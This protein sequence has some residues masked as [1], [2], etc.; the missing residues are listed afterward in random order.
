MFPALHLFVPLGMCDYLNVYHNEYAY[1][2][3]WRSSTLQFLSRNGHLM[4]D[5]PSYIA[6]GHDHETQDI[7]LAFSQ[8][9]RDPIL[10]RL[11]RLREEHKL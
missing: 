5:N 1:G 6:P 7:D 2:A 4:H 8:F 3:W 11:Y 9:S 10:D